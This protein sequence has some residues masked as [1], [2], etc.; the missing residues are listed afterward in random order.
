M[1]EQELN[2]WKNK[3]RLYKI[4]HPE[5]FEIQN[6]DRCTPKCQGGPFLSLLETGE[7]VEIKGWWDLPEHIYLCWCIEWI[8]Y[9]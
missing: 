7:I 3:F 9:E 4:F 2:K 6:C 5:G 1:S 8:K